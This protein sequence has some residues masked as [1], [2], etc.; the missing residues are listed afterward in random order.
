MKSKVQKHF[1]MRI[2]G[3]LSA[4]YLDPYQ[5]EWTQIYSCLKHQHKLQSSETALLQFSRLWP[6][7]FPTIRWSQLAQL[8]V[9]NKALFSKFIQNQNQFDTA[10]LFEV[11]IYEY[12]K[13][14]YVSEKVLPLQSKN[15]S[16][17]FQ[18]ILIINSII[19]LKF[20]YEIHVENDPSQLLFDWAQKIKPEKKQHHFGIR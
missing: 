8:D 13:T 1:F 5:E 11:E 6:M 10:W 12:W 19:P 4:P 2:S 15:L 20:A 16:K 9:T 14:H 7:N 18:R 17:S 3:M